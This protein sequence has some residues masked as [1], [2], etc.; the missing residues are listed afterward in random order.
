VPTLYTSLDAA[1]VR[2]EVIRTTERQ[3]LPEEASYPLR[4][5]RLELTAEVVDLR[6]PGALTSLG[7]EQALFLAPLA[8]TRAIGSAASRLRV[9]A[10]IV[11]SITSAGDNA[12]IF[13]PSVGS[14]P[15]VIETVDLRRSA[16][17]P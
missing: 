16:D 17:W 14:G 12:V 4:L 9:G 2:A 6:E 5:G 13:P 1:T 11:P 10:L 15:Q 8:A 7:V 3:G